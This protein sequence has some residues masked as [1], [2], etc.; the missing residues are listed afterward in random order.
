[1]LIFTCDFYSTP[2]KAIIS[3]IK[4]NDCPEPQLESSRSDNLME[5]KTHSLAWH[6]MQT[7]DFIYNN[8]GDYT[9]VRPIRTK[10]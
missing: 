7:D 4:S 1:M 2:V 10:H 3:F 9:S 8:A 5:E 6:G